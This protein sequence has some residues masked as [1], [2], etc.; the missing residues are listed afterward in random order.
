M[1]C[2]VVIKICKQESAEILSGKC[3]PHLGPT[4]S[5]LYSWF[6]FKLIMTTFSFTLLS[7]ISFK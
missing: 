4:T 3:A 1:K 6:M 2:D 5:V 7:T